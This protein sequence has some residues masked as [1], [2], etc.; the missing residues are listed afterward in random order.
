MLLNDILLHYG[1]KNIDAKRENIP[2][3]LA[4]DERMINYNNLFFKTSCPT[5]DNYDFLER[6]DTL[7]DLLIDLPNEKT[8]II[9]S[10][11][12]QNEMLKSK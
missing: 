2:K 3:N 10:T 4:K 7:Y 8:S 9:K 6:F 1:D 12:E 11:K 5:I